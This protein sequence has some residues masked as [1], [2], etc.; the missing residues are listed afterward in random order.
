MKA[1]KEKFYWLV[2]HK[3]YEVDCAIIEQYHDCLC[4]AYTYL[5]LPVFFTKKAANAYATGSQSVVKIK[6]T[7]VK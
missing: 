4:Q 1:K 5:G 2:T 6:I 3:D 7:I